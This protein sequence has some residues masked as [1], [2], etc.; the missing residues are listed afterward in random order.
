[1]L[2]RAFFGARFLSSLPR[3]SGSLAYV[4]GVRVQFLEAAMRSVNFGVQQVGLLLQ[5]RSF[6][7]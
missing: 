5:F 1:M 6:L 7:R 3:D 2:G 4:R